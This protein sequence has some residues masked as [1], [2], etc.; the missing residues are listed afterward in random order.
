M[1]E[2]TARLQSRAI[3][4]EPDTQALHRP[5]SI[6]EPPIPAPE[7]PFDP[8]SKL[9]RRIMPALTVEPSISAV[10]EGIS[11]SNDP[12]S[13]VFTKIVVFA[14]LVVVVVVG[15]VKWF[16]PYTI[17]NLKELVKAID[18]LIDENTTVEWDLLGGSA[19]EFRQTLN[20]YVWDG[21]H[22]ASILTDFRL[23]KSFQTSLYNRQ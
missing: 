22:L 13:S 3:L 23:S 12:G 17:E 5:T 2:I 11:A 10:A 20:R 18:N 6:S 4:F 7:N 21:A 9:I 8:T 15:V 14:M 16:F 1:Y 19:R